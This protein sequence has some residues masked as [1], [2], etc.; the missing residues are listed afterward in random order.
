MW[1]TD[2]DGGH[3]VVFTVGVLESI[4]GTGLVCEVLRLLGVEVVWSGV[5]WSEVLLDSYWAVF[6]DSYG[7]GVGVSELYC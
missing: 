2:R 5:V 4:V 7:G 1:L 6:R 3:G